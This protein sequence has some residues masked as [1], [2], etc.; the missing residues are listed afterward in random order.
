M[1]GDVYRICQRSEGGGELRG[2]GRRRVGLAVSLR[3]RPG[4]QRDDQIYEGDPF[5]VIK[6][7]RSG[8]AHQL[9]SDGT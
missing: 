4:P 2:D 8:D 5:E 3:R 7:R 9:C 1:H 6:P